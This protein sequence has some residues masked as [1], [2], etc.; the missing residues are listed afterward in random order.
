MRLR[1]ETYKNPERSKRRKSSIR[2]K[3]HGVLENYFHVNEK[4]PLKTLF[5]EK[6]N[7]ISM[8]RARVQHRSST[9]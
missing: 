4:S 5:I 9:S 3:I 8:I 7:K 1:P 2:Y 6:S